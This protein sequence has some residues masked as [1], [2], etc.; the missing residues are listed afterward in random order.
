MKTELRITAVS[1]L[2]VTLSASDGQCPL[3]R[4]AFLT[5]AFSLS[6]ALLMWMILRTWP[7]RHPVD[8]RGHGERRPGTNPRGAAT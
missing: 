6:I 4:T 3:L 7:G 8:G 5:E 1:Y 2:G